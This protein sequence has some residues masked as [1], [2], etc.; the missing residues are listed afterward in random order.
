MN[1]EIVRHRFVDSQVENLNHCRSLPGVWVWWRW[2]WVWVWVWR[3]A[4]GRRWRRRGRWR[5]RRRRRLCNHAALA[6][7]PSAGVRCLMISSAY[8][9]SYWPPTTIQHGVARACMQCG[10]MRGV[11]LPFASALDVPLLDAWRSRYCTNH[12]HSRSKIKS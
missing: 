9:P 7:S 10:T 6:L 12:K 11:C 5:R 4:E 2:V 3:S 8:V 1:H